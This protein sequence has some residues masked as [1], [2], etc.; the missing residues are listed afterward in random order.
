MTEFASN[1][2]VKPREEGPLQ[3]LGTNLVCQSSRAA[4]D[5][6]KYRVSDKR[7]G[8]IF[9]GMA[10]AQ[11][12]EVTILSDSHF[13]QLIVTLQEQQSKEGL[14]LATALQALLFFDGLDI[15]EWSITETEIN[16]KRIPLNSS[17]VGIVVQ[18]S[19]RLGMRPRGLAEQT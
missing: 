18:L 7:V 2:R 4:L 5:V 11:G 3:E 6:Q 15:T 10:V 19:A 12:V 16:P 1:S 17:L 14:S 13:L 8:N 9:Y